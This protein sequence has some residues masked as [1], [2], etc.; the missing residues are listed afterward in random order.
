MEDMTRKLHFH[1]PDKTTLPQVVF[2]FY[3]ALHSYSILKKHMS[4]TP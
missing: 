3:G 4:F 1:D 2:Y